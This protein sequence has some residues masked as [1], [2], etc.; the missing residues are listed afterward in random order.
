LFIVVINFGGDGK[1]KLKKFI[2][3]LLISLLIQTV[4]LGSIWFFLFG[5]MVLW[6]FTTMASA[7]CLAFVMFFSSSGDAWTNNV[8]ADSFLHLVDSGHREPRAMF[9]IRV[10]P[11]LVSSLLILLI[12]IGGSTVT[13]YLL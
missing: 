2:Q 3:I 10:N 13:H 6:D 9:Q 1:V 7:I 5:N 12:S 8:I 11:I 4:L